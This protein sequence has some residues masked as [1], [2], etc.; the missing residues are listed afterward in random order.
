VILTNPPFGKRG[1]NQAPNR[2]DFTV[3]TSNKQFNFIQHV[4][5]ILKPGGRAAVVVPDNVLFEEKAGEVFKIL[6]E[7]CE[8]HTVLRCPFGTFTPYTQGTQTNVIFFT[9]GRPTEHAWIYDV[10]ANV[11]RVTKKSRPLTAGHFAEFERCYGSEPN[12][13]SPRAEADSPDDRWRAFSIDEI[14]QRHYKI[15]GFKWL[16]DDEAG[17]V[18]DLPHPG[19]LI[20]EAISELRLALEA[21]DEMQVLLTSSDEADE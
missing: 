16:R 2:D 19:E 9:K 4:I 1:A 17:G 18:E 13:R 14:K 8:V 7:D 3:A 11:P 6:M 5:T 21:L 20:T 12:G 10:R 15:N